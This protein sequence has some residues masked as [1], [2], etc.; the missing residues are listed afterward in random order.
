MQNLSEPENCVHVQWAGDILP[1]LSDYEQFILNMG[2]ELPLV[3]LSTEQAITDFMLLFLT[4]ESIDDNRNVKL[5]EKGTYSHGKIAPEKSLLL[6][7]ELIGTF[8][9]NGIFH[10]D[11]NKNKVP[12]CE[13]QGI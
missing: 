6:R 5:T 7:I 3:C 12:S 1:D 13:C 4:F 11:V 8:P 2:E 9:N 10:E